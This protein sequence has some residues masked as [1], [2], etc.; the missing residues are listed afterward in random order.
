MTDRTD[1]V[2]LLG[3][4]KESLRLLHTLTDDAEAEYQPRGYDA[5]R[6]R[7]RSGGVERPIPVH[8]DS[9]GNPTGRALDGPLS[10][11]QAHLRAALADLTDAGLGVVVAPTRVYAERVPQFA[12]HLDACRRLRFGLEHVEGRIAR[13]LDD[14]LAQAVTDCCHAILD[15][16]DAWPK[17]LTRPQR[18]CAGRP[19]WWSPRDGEWELRPKDCDRRLNGRGERCEACKRWLSRLR[20]FLADTG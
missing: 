10:A 13:G 19:E 14:E 1:L 2:V 11:S 9:D 17:W 7:M 18:L 15:A 3:V 4:A 6:P 16:V 8:L 5:D 12:D 20:A